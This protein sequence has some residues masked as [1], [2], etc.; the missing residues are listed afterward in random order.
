MSVR[1]ES[2][3]SSLW[4]STLVSVVALSLVLLLSKSLFALIPA[5]WTLAFSAGIIAML[6]HP[7]SVGTSMV[8]CIAL[9]AG[10]DFAIHLGFRARSY[11]EHK[12]GDRAVRELGAVIFVSAAQLAL[13]FSVQWSS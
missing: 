1:A 6:G 4:H 7:I 9:G 5:I 10:V 13:A 8:S 3:T 2:V 11:D 12:R